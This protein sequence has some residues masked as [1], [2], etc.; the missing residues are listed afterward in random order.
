M[1]NWPDDAARLREYDELRR[2]LAE[3]KAENARLR[4]EL[5]TA[6]RRTVLLCPAGAMMDAMAASAG[7]PEGTIIR[8]TDDPALAFELKEGAWVPM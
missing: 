4:A 8:A 5:D 2:Q 3:L 1:V 7:E 6:G